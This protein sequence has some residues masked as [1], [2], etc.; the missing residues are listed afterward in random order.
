[1]LLF[2]L[3]STDDLSN[4][5]NIRIFRSLCLHLNLLHHH[6]LRIAGWEKTLSLVYCRCRH[7]HPHSHDL[8]ICSYSSSIP[9]CIITYK[10][11]P[12]S[13][14]YDNVTQ[15]KIEVIIHYLSIVMKKSNLDHN[16]YINLQ[17]PVCLCPL[18]NH[19]PKK[20]PVLP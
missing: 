19:W 4:Y 18:A 20:D 8:S 3:Q 2:H 7:P 12:H 16:F 5:L 11:L 9:E 14:F 1:M 6:G 13:I 17:W 10:S 15:I